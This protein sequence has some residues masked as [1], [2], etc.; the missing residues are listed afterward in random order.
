MSE[1]VIASTEA[2]A[3]SATPVTPEK[4]PVS[5]NSRP[6]RGRGKGGR[7]R[8]GGRREPKEFEEEVLD[9]ARVTRVV[10]GGRRMRFLATVAIGNKKG[11]VGLGTGK[12]VEVSVAIKKAVQEAKK[13]LIDVALVEGTIPYDKEV[14]YKAAR[15]RIMPAPSGTGVIAGGSFRK[16]AMLAGITDVYAK[17][18]GSNSS[19]V[20]AQASI[21][22][23]S[24]FA[25]LR[26]DASSE[27]QEK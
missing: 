7:G 2:T 3:E 1:E 14:K 10:K 4:K 9:I 22:A 13:N 17:S 19:L 11:R 21:K 5:R 15:I 23:L 16:I 12:S 26:K 24:S 20:S 8:K 27:L 25:R 6:P 18:I